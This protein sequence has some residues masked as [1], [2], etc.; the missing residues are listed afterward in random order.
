M[1]LACAPKSETVESDVASSSVAYKGLLPSKVVVRLDLHRSQALAP[2]KW[3]L[4]YG[5]PLPIRGRPCPDSPLAR[6]SKGW[7]VWG[8]NLRPDHCW[9]SWLVWGNF[10]K[11]REPG[12]RSLWRR[13]VSALCRA[14]KPAA[15][16]RTEELG[17][18]IAS[19]LSR[20]DKRSEI[21]RTMVCSPGSPKSSSSRT[22]RSWTHL[23]G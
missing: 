19:V 11:Y 7:V 5:A 15:E 10:C 23:E 13:R 12:V 3:W 6:R 20:A 22:P 14:R 21:L 8:C 16:T 1:G 9:D 18:G 4:S 2:Y 17:F